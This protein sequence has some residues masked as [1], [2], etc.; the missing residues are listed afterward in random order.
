MVDLSTGNI[1][2][3]KRYAI[4]TP[5][6]PHISFLP[7]ITQLLKPGGFTFPGMATTASM[8]LDG[9]NG[10]K[11]PFPTWCFCSDKG[12]SEMLGFFFSEWPEAE[13]VLVTRSGLE[14]CQFAARRQVTTTILPMVSAPLFNPLQQQMVHRQCSCFAAATLTLL[15]ASVIIFDDHVGAQVP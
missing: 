8:T 13:V 6:H 10:S 9:I 5:K 12:R 11:A 7:T 15:G 14:L 1:S 4:K 2:V 3:H